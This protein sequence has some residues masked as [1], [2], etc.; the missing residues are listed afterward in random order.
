MAS[1]TVTRSIVPQSDQGSEFKVPLKGLCRKL[2]V[3]MVHSRPYHPQWQGKIERSNGALR[4]KMEYDFFKK[5]QKKAAHAANERCHRRMV[6]THLK[7]N[8]PSGYRVGE[9]V[10]I[11]LSKKGKTSRKQQVI[12]ALVEERNLKQQSYKVSFKSL[13]GVN[14][15]GSVWLTSQS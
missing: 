1:K 14:D 15:G 11:R 2:K 9:K 4:S 3:K 8:P 12:E 10:L 7:S 5:G 13:E 6:K